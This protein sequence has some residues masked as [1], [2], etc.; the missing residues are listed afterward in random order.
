MPTTF[1]VFVDWDGD[2]SWD[3]AAAN[4]TRYVEDCQIRLG[5]SNEF[6]HIADIGACVLTLDNTSKL[7]SPAYAAGAL[8]GN[9]VPGRAVRVRGT[10]GVT[11]WTL[12]LG[13]IVS[14]YAEA[15]E[16]GRKQAV[17]E[18][19]DR[20][21]TL[22]RT[23]LGLALQTNR[24]MSQMLSLICSNVWGG[25]RATGSITVVGGLLDGHTV[26]V[27]D[28][29]YR[30][31]SAPAQANDVAIVALA[32]DCAT[33]LAAAINGDVTLSGTGYHADTRRHDAVSASASGA[34]VTLTALEA[35]AVYNAVGL[36]A[37][38]AS[39]SIS[40]DTLTGG[41]DA[42][43]GAISFASGTQTFAV[44]ADRWQDDVTTGMSAAEQVV[45][46]EF[47]YL[48]VARDGTLTAKDCNWEFTLPATAASLTL[49]GQGV[50]LDNAMSTD[51][52]ANR[53]VVDYQPRGYEAEGVVARA[54]NVI[55]VPGMAGMGSSVEGG[56]WNK[57]SGYPGGG[58][59]TP[60]DAK[61][62][63]LGFVDTGAGQIIGAKDIITPVAGT[64]Y[65]VN[66]REDG[67][68]FNYTNTGRVK[69]SAA[70]TG[71]GV[72][73]TFT[74]SATG[75]L[76]VIGLQ[77]R[78]TAVVAFDTQQIIR[79]DATSIAAYHKRSIN[80]PISLPSSEVFAES[81]ANYLLGRY[82]NPRFAVRS[83]RVHNTDLIGAVH[84]LSVE[85]GDV[86]A[87]TDQQLGIS[88]QKYLVRGF[89]CSITAGGR[90]YD[91]TWPLKRLDDTTYWILDDATYSVLDSTTRLA[92]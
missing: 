3:H 55:M 63:R 67:T 37:S 73:L 48:W 9:L 85:I 92:I 33:N 38:A 64:D 40:N 22:Y 27:G 26:T 50:A 52:M 39:C 23:T 21:G 29:M 81:A 36:A 13:E 24:T 43:V 66:D 18:C 35:G 25:V 84:P 71:G 54:N 12:F 41:A 75:P 32:A 59:D 2:N 69:V 30:W 72:E 62:V 70:V 8:Y 89:E 1:D 5:F 65:T 74:N 10:D 28:K 91:V 47:G 88:A 57:S 16:N 20:M 17:I 11:T 60:V 68:G 87:V 79:E 15:G 77:V 19:E 31:M 86:V 51:D 4:I 56:R 80:Y 61:V 53:V 34:V 83:A 49:A 46:S 45:S 78:G 58:G 7:F 42:P 14:L 82:K 44:A 6:R 76:Y 90:A